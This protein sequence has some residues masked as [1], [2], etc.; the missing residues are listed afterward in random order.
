MSRRGS[1]GAGGLAPC[2]RLH[3]ARP[4]RGATGFA[5]RP[6]SLAV[7]GRWMVWL[8]LE[9]MPPLMAFQLVSVLV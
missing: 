7:L 8:P 1:R 2:L 4:P 5:S 9:A 6:A 3:Y